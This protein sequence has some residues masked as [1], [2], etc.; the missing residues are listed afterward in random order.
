MKKHNLTDND[1]FH[2]FPVSILFFR[3]ILIP[4]LF[5]YSTCGLTL[6]LFEIE[7]SKIP[8]VYGHIVFGDVNGDGY[9]D[10]VTSGME[11]YR[12][13]AINTPP[14]PT[15]VIIEPARIWLN[16]KRGGFIPSKQN[17]NLGGEFGYS[18]YSLETVYISVGDIDN[19][20][21]N[22]IVSSTGNI[23][24][25]DGQGNFEDSIETNVGSVDK[26]IY[27][28]DL[29]NDGIPEIIN[30]NLEIYKNTSF[31][32]LQYQI[33][34]DSPAWGNPNKSVVLRDFN[35]D[36]Y[37]DFLLYS[38]NS[39]I[40]IYINDGHGG[41]SS[42]NKHVLPYVEN[43]HLLES[44][45]D[46]DG[47]LDLILSSNRLLINNLNGEFLLIDL[48][49]ELSSYGNPLDGASVVPYK[50]TKLNNDNYIDLV[51]I[52]DLRNTYGDDQ[53]LAYLVL[54]GD[55]S[56]QF[57]ANQNL[58]DSQFLGNYKYDDSYSYGGL[59]VDWYRRYLFVDFNNDGFDDIFSP[60]SFPWLARY[61]YI[62]TDSFV[63]GDEECFYRYYCFSNDYQNNRII[64]LSNPS[65]N[66]SNKNL[67]NLSF[68]SMNNLNSKVADLDS[69][70]KNELIYSSPLYV[71]LS[72]AH[73]ITNIP[74]YLLSNFNSSGFDVN[75]LSFLTDDR[76]HSY[77]NLNPIDFNNDGLEDL[78]TRFFV[79]DIENF[80]CDVS[81]RVLVNS[82]DGIDE[83]NFVTLENYNSSETTNADINGDGFPDLI[84]EIE[85]TSEGYKIE[86]GLNLN[87]TGVLV[88]N[89]ILP[90]YSY[91][92]PELN[93]YDFNND[94]YD[95]ILFIDDDSK[96]RIIYGVNDVNTFQTEYL[97]EEI[98]ESYDLF[99][100]DKDGD[101]D[102]FTLNRVGNTT[103]LKIRKYDN[104]R[105]SSF[106]KQ[107]SMN[108]VNSVDSLIVNDLNNDNQPDLLVNRHN[109]YMIDETTE[110]Y[111]K[112]IELNLEYHREELLVKIVD[113]DG[114]GFKDIIYGSQIFLAREYLFET[115]LHYD[116]QHSGHGFSIE[117]VGE[118]L[119]YT[120]FY[121]YDE[122]NEPTWYADLGMFE[123]QQDDYWRISDQE[124][125]FFKYFYDYQTQTYYQSSDI[126]DKGFLAHDK[127]SDE[128]GKIGL[129]YGFGEKNIQ[130]VPIGEPQEYGEWCSKSMIDYYKHPENNL[131]GLW[132]AGSDD[133]GWGWSVS[134]IER[135]PENTDMVV[136]LYYYDGEGNPRWL[137]GQQS[138]F[139]P[140]KEM[141]ITMNMVKG[142]QRS[143]TPTNLELFEAG[144]MT[145]TLNQASRNFLN[146]GTMSID[147]TYPGPE[148]GSWIRNS[149]PIALQ[150][151]PRN[152]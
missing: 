83:D 152:R 54:F 102:L 53:G 31:S 11:R 32:P 99:D 66:N 141:T 125:N 108:D 75:Q 115:G 6:E 36:N 17:I 44:D 33:Q 9:N 117:N 65:G 85:R 91:D 90:N 29:D 7:S 146:A 142:Y 50:A 21:D 82:E 43:H 23:L 27:I 118:D 60:V 24:L 95:D 130:G 110:S 30:G 64:M 40:E 14:Q 149:I 4:V 109:I 28:K 13:Y 86:I 59:N 112:K 69:D 98:I 67:A 58:S 89:V 26:S 97:L 22:D 3:N 128:F 55:G 2:N 8:E 19:D 10:M 77:L 81:S 51:V 47:D 124:L 107:Q 39:E 106:Y 104:G 120:V 151:T 74:S 114:D 135:N 52:I 103:Y 121:T 132:W 57:R 16:D 94:G 138:G 145:L 100:L 143:Q 123:E 126:N 127:C 38:E 139:E 140:G 12:H 92:S 113:L 116:P 68:S 119:F 88:E 144:T 137:I 79:C 61:E 147:V 25:N 56:G 18:N 93:F 101:L 80:D 34:N 150:S 49:T 15:P 148:G 42:E 78:Q 122:N 87:G 5:I 134:L 111:R 45:I 136:V 41:F 72:K 131:S 37:S 76:E 133:S 35:N 73:S 62:T 1:K 63:S 96:L 46:N 48:I 105:F 20:G 129:I 84:G 71:S 70:G